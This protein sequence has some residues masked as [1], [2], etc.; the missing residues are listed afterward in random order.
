MRLLVSALSSFIVPTVCAVF[1]SLSHH[2]SLLGVSK[3]E[4]L[5]VLGIMYSILT[6]EL[7]QFANS[8]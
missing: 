7:F 2:I 8:C 5:L 6:N 3:Y 4:V 1:Q